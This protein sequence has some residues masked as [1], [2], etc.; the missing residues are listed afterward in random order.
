MKIH[1]ITIG[2]PKLAYAKTGWDEY[3]LR[4][5]HYHT[6]R[7]THLADKFINDTTKI[8]E[9]CGNGFTVSLVIDG[10]EFTSESLA[11]LL[12]DKELESREVVFII[13]GSTGLP[14]QVIERTDLAWSLGRLTFPHD[15]AM[16]VT[17]EALYRASTITS[18]HPYHK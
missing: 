1:I 14:E 6:V 11:N 4:L 15:L 18:G 12:R 7:V 2:K 17:A 13:G 5:R 9:A 10:K 16:V 3:I 8:L